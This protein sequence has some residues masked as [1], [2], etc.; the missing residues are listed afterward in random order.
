MKNWSTSLAKLLVEFLMLIVL[1]AAGGA[2]ASTL[3]DPGPK[4]LAIAAFDAALNI[5]PL[6]LAISLATGMVSFRVPRKNPI[7]VL[8]SVAFVGLILAAAGVWARGF[9]WHLPEPP[10]PTV[11]IGQAVE[12]GDRLAMVSAVRGNSVSGLVTVDWAGPMPRLGWYA[13][14]P[15]DP[16]ESRAMAAEKDWYLIPGRSDED[17]LATSAG[18]AFFDSFHP[19]PLVAGEGIVAEMARAAG[20]VLL[21]IGFGSF[22]FGLRRPMSALI[23]ATLMA[24]AVVFGDSWF[25][26]SSLPE[27]VQSHIGGLA[28]GIETRWVLPA[29]EAVIGLA[30]SVIGLA[31]SR[32]ERK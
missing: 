25:V 15:F 5:W 18:P 24:L 22:A 10:K 9:E 32:R 3:D 26:A 17:A 29:I 23:L 1:F 19:L 7:M 2:F 16:L 27:L 30:T 20:F 6:A 13:A 4:A 12:N 14:A 21:C 8:L 11:A 28:N 31:F